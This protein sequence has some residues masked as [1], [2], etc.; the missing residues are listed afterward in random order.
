MD[1]ARAKR[2][3]TSDS[4]IAV[5]LKRSRQVVSQWRNGD[6][7]PDEDLIVSLAEMAGDDP[8][9]WLVAVRAIR[10][11]GK[12]G[13]AWAALAKRLA[14]TTLIFLCAIGFTANPL[15]AK[16]N[17]AETKSETR[18]VCILCQGATSLVGFACY[19]AH[20][21]TTTMARRMESGACVIEN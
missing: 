18:V 17:V 1:K 7:Y 9:E 21:A 15:I 10:S 5:E 19:C 3:L 11:E 14:A 8:S 12:A 20:A 16:A 13:K 6:A 2:G 4:A